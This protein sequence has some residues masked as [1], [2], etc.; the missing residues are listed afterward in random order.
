MKLPTVC[1][2]VPIVEVASECVD[3]NTVAVAP[4]ID[5]I[6]SPL[7]KS[8]LVLISKIFVVGWKFTTVPE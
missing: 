1:P 7:L 5:V 2:T 3:W 4:V 6:L 8:T